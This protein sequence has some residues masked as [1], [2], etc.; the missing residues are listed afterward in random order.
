MHT[1]AEHSATAWMRTVQAR[2]CGRAWRRDS[3]QCPF[4]SSGRWTFLVCRDDG[5][6]VGPRGGME[7]RRIHGHG[8]RY[9]ADYHGRGVRNPSPVPHGLTP[10]GLPGIVSVKAKEHTKHT[11]QESKAKMQK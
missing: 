5:A 10:G 4:A 6:S 8:A 9:L 2:R 1:E 11:K 7:L 3:F